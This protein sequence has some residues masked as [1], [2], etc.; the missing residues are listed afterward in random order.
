MNNSLKFH[1]LT[2][3][4]ITQLSNKQL[5]S[6][7]IEEIK[8]QLVDIDP[9]FN[10]PEL[11]NISH[12]GQDYQLSLHQKTSHYCQDYQFSPPQKKTYL[13]LTFLEYFP[14]P[15][16][17]GISA[18]IGVVPIYSIVDL[19][20]DIE[21]ENEIEIAMNDVSFNIKDKLHFLFFK[22]FVDYLSM[23]EQSQDIINLLLNMID[24]MYYTH[25][26]IMYTLQKV[27][28]YARK[29]QKLEN[30]Y[31]KY[32]LIFEKIQ[33]DT[34]LDR[35]IYLLAKKSLKK[36]QHHLMKIMKN[37]KNN[38]TIAQ[39]I[40]ITT[41]GFANDL[42][43]CYDSEM[44]KLF[45]ILVDT[46]SS[47]ELP[48]K[49]PINIKES[50]Y[51]TYIGQINKLLAIYQGEK[52]NQNIDNKLETSSESENDSESEKENHEEEKQ[53]MQQNKNTGLQ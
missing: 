22:A 38:N 31:A 16:T 14:P 51:A 37:C 53:D 11:H 34:I 1:E 19:A 28:E 25:L 41:Y 46:L 8:K 6:I 15:N 3:E 35:Y 36:L 17:Y 24:L 39:Q 26:R 49:E 40:I 30:I 29:H 5:Q 20:N 32:K 18:T 7:N 12:Y 48:Q 52:K 43:Y 45:K 9:A 4:D 21:N 10:N 50:Q 27:I 44:K 23:E 42:Y 47:P 2:I 13:N 33:Q